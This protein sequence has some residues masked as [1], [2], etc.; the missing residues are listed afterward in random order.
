LWQ[1]LL[2]WAFG[3]AAH[4]RQIRN[5]DEKALPAKG[6]SRMSF[7]TGMADRLLTLVVPR[8]TAS[9]YCTGCGTEFCYC[10]SSCVV[11][12]KTCCINATCKGT[13]CGACYA[14]SQT[15]C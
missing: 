5:S 10:S 6:G 1:D 7:V 15:C 13:H 9:A 3:L 12:E 11:Y 14:T 8:A 4:W 2:G